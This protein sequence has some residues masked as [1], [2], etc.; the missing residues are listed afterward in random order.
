MNGTELELQFE[1]G[2]DWKFFV[3]PLHLTVYEVRLYEMA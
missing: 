1:T 3:N 2:R